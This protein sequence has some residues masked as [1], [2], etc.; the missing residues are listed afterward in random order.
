METRNQSKFYNFLLF[1]SSCVVV[2][3]YADL[4]PNSY[5]C[6]NFHLR[7]YWKIS[8]LVLPIKC[9]TKCPKN[10]LCEPMNFI[11]SVALD[12]LKTFGPCFQKLLWS[13]ICITKLNKISCF[14][15]GVHIPT[16]SVKLETGTSMNPTIYSSNRSLV[17]FHDPIRFI[18]Y[19]HRCWKWS[20]CF[21][22]LYLYILKF[23]CI[24]FLFL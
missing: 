8:Y 18:A 23:V 12:I 10:G 14:F 2:Y 16:I 6:G 22:F 21:V 4:K 24:A 15:A 11:S 9:S 1:V 5:F 3:V 20:F 13:H 19:N 7:C 17:M